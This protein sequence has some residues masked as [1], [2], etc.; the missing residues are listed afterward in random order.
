QVPMLHVSDHADNYK[1]GRDGFGR[2]RSPEPDAL[3]QRLF[4]RKVATNEGP[5]DNRY[6]QRLPSVL[7][8][9]LASTLQPNS[10]RAKVIG[11][12]DA[13]IG[14]WR[15]ARPRCR[16]SFDQEPRG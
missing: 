7:P 4:V 3:T 9:E 10:H 16:P 12:D 6:G 11:T 1:P 2:G 14:V 8:A 15:I 5:I 13:I